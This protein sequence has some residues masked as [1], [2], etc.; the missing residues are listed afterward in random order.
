MIKRFKVLAGE[1]RMA[2]NQAKCMRIYQW[3]ER[4]RSAMHQRQIVTLCKGE[5]SPEY[6]HGIVARE[7]LMKYIV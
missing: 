7:K 6:F 2:G 3:S 1:Q 5:D 4:G